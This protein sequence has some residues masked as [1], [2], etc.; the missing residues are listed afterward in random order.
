MRSS[1]TGVRQTG[2]G[3]HK[4]ADG[5]ASIGLGGKRLMRVKKVGQ[6]EPV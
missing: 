1:R 4:S 5:H 6:L 3:S 2:A